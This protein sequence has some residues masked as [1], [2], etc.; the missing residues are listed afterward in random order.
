MVKLTW[1]AKQQEAL[2]FS[3]PSL[4]YSAVFLL[5]LFQ[6]C[7]SLIQIKPILSRLMSQLSLSFADLSGLYQVQMALLFDRL[8]M[9]IPVCCQ[10]S[11]HYLICF[12]AMSQK[13][14]N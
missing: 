5:S 4:T 9:E 1:L 8:Q 13:S 6:V 11:S 14:I 3:M 12:L 7:Y 2:R 10:T